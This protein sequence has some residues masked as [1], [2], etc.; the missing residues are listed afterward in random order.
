MIM[1]NKEYII[2]R[3][4]EASATNTRKERVLSNI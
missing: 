1:E 2:E 3:N 4:T